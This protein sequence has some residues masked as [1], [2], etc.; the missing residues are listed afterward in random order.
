MSDLL[1]RSATSLMHFLCFL[2]LHQRFH[3]S[4]FPG[5]SAF[6]GQA[7]LSHVSKAFNTRDGRDA[8]TRQV[9]RTN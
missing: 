2:L 3:R 6:L 5:G 9:E 1:R 8:D 4:R 7:Q